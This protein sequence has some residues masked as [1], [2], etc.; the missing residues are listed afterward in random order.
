MSI[1]C[2]VPLLIATDL[3]RV[4]SASASRPPGVKITGI[5]CR[6]GCPARPPK[7]ENVEFFPRSGD[8]LAAGFR[9][10][11]RCTPMQP[12]GRYPDWLQPLMTAV[13]DD[14]LRRSTGDSPSRAVGRIALKVAQ[15]S[16]PRGPI[17]VAGDD[18]AVYLVEFWDRRML[19]TQFAVL[20]KRIGA[21]FFPGSTPATNAMARELEAYFAGELD[22]FATPIRYPGTDHQVAVW[23]TLRELPPGETWSYGELAERLGKPTAVRSVARAVGENRFAIVIPCHRIVGANGQL[24]GYG[25]GLWRKRCLLKHERGEVL[26]GR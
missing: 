12:S 2:I 7:R 24:T 5:F 18:E 15:L 14:P 19:E 21:A 17:M 3:S 9:P 8:A 6:P 1:P 23:E 4:F 16:S 20:E 10:C 26:L 25:G 11:K 13:D 22:H